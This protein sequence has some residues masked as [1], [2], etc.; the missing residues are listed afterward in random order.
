MARVILGL[1]AN[2][3]K[4]L[5][6]LRQAIAEIGIAIGSVN[7]IS[8]VYQSKALLPKGAPSSWDKDYYNIAIEVTTHL[9][10]LPLLHQL[11]AIEIQLGREKDHPMWSPRVIDIDILAYDNLHFDHPD[12]MIPH[13]GLLLRRFALE[14]LLEILPTWCYPNINIDLHQQLQKLPP[15]D[16]VPFSIK[17]TKI[18][19]VV[20]LSRDSF[21]SGE[22]VT[23]VDDFE[24][25]IIAM[26]HSGA[27]IIDIGAES[28]K[29][30]AKAKTPEAV[31]Q[32][33]SPYSQ[34]LEDLLRR[35]EFPLTVEV[36]IDTYHTL[37][38]EQALQFNCVSMINDIYG[39]NV[40]DIVNLIKDTA[41][42]YIFMHHCGKAGTDYLP[43]EDCVDHILAY[44][45]AQKEILLGY[46]LQENQLI[47][48]LGIGF[49]KYPFQAKRLLSQISYI[50]QHL[51][52]PLLV[53][54]SR[55]N[56]V[57]PFLHGATVNDKD[58]ACAI[59][60]RDLCQQGVDYVRVHN[61]NIN[62]VARFI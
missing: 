29:P 22:T 15:I 13:K 59:I 1:G 58:I 32:L 51:K 19:G 40:P 7:K 9:A 24:K 61:V 42:K 12:L 37:V 41:I 21:S 35:H 17:G 10:P 60:T 50:K 31:W 30:N 62:A 6:Y 36:S 18:M 44:A 8:S 54:H 43:I 52:L 39:N 49:G 23:D 45:S 47:F 16:F 5:D 27:E 14:P 48:D 26:V 11:Q 3:G 53:G 33:L 28:T 20:N 25:K 56:S 55:K 4:K 2:L 38:V 34:K 46:G 57:A